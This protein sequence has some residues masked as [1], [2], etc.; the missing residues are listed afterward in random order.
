MKKIGMLF[1]LLAGALLAAHAQ[2]QAP[3]QYY[4]GVGVGAMWS[5]GASPY[6]NTSD[7]KRATGGKIYAGK[8]AGSWGLELSGYHLGDYDVKFNNVTIAESK[9]RAIFVSAVYVTDLG[10]G[11]TFHAKGGIGFTR[12]TYTCVSSCGTGTPANVD[13]ETDNLSGM[14]AL[15][16]G[17]RLTQNIEA[18]MDWEHVGSFHHAVS[19]TTYKESVDMFT[20]S[21]QFGF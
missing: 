15:G 18:R 5:N 12:H 1:A 4:F 16:F 6:T 7:D 8:M 3:G 2:A 13:T 9:P 20:V 21:L 19:T 17:S 10:G 11:Y 14:W